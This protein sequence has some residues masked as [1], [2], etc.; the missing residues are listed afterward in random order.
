MIWAE[1]CTQHLF[2]A[3]CTKLER[4]PFSTFAL[5][6]SVLG[7]ILVAGWHPVE[8]EVDFSSFMNA[9]SEASKFAD[10]YTQALSDRV[11]DTRRLMRSRSY[12][13]YKFHV[14][15]R[16]LDGNVLDDAPLRHMRETELKLRSLPGFKELCDTM[17]WPEDRFKCTPGESL[18]NYIW[19]SPNVEATPEKNDVLFRLHF[20]GKGDEHERV[21]TSVALALLQSKEHNILSKLFPKD[22][23]WQSGVSPALQSN[24]VFNLHTGTSNDAQSEILEIWKQQ[25]ANTKT[26]LRMSCIRCSQVKVG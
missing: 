1:K 16:S 17:V 21:P 23:Q 25:K 24:F 19:P 3:Y 20:D 8:I 22:F 5:Y 26:F 14:I 10:C 13:Q 15:Y 4:N 18:V 2:L 11:D 9:D 6:V 7:V 12:V